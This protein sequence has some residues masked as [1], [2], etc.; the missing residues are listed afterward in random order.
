MRIPR[1]VAEEAK[2]H[3]NS[4]VDLAIRNGK[5]VVTPLEEATFTLQSLLGQVTD[6]NRHDEIATGADVGNEV[7]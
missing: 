4:Q 2:L 6:E 3:E 7:W 1:L 5:L